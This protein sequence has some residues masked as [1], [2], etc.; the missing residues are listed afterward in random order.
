M[1]DSNKCGYC[2]KTFV[3]SST[4][5]KHVCEQKRRHLAKSEKHVM[6]GYQAFVKFFQFTQNGKSIKT[7]SEFS[8]SPY[9]NAFV[10][11]GSYIS[12]VNPMYPDQYIDWVIKSGVK[13]DNWCRDALYEQ[14]ALDLIKTEPVEVALDRTIKHMEGWA[15]TNGTNWNLYFV[16]V[17]PNRVTYD[18]RDGKVSP[19]LV[20][21]SPTGKSLLSSLTDEQLSSISNTINPEFWLKKFKNQTADLA[22]VKQVVKEANL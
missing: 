5:F 15:K 9:Y 21:N 16:N 17:S 13:L 11:F 12:N 6:I 7:Y 4:L 19:W 10:K 22:L 3:K 20:L 14:Y 1:D 18:I 2:G 8:E